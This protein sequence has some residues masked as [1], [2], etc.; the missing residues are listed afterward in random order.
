M[1]WQYPGKWGYTFNGTILGI[2]SPITIPAGPVAAAGSFVLDKAGNMAASQTVNFNGSAFPE[3][4]AGTV[5][6]NPDCT[7]VAIFK[8]S[9]PLPPRTDTLDFVLVDNQTEAFMVFGSSVLH[10]SST[11]NANLPGIITVKAKRLFEFPW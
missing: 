9:G 2:Q 8:L 3:T 11:V 4:V 6:V 1:A 5:T 7:G 10:L